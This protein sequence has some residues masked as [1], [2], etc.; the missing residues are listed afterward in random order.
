MTREKIAQLVA[1]HRPEAL[2]EHMVYEVWE[3]G[4]ITL[5]K[6]ADLYGQRNL[7][8]ISMGREDKALPWAEFPEELRRFKT[9]ARVA[10]MT[11]E[12]ALAAQALVLGD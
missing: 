1:M 8:C 5:T 6:G 4:E 11:H 3:D 7:H 2:G 9:H 10:V 12:D